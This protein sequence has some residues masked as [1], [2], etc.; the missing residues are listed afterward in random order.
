MAAKCE[1]GRGLAVAEVR[2]DTVRSDVE[3]EV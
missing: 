3:A 1:D 2:R